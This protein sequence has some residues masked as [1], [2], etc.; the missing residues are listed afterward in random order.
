M[1]KNYNKEL[2]YIQIIHFWFRLFVFT[3]VQFGG[4]L[5]GLGGR[6]QRGGR[7]GVMR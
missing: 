6:E 7:W 2:K 4:E 3:F 5:G 1:T